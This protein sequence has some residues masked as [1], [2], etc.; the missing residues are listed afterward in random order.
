MN[1]MRGMRKEESPVPP[2]QLGGFPI[3][4]ARGRST[5]YFILGSKRHKKRGEADYSNSHNA[6]I[7]AAMDRLCGV[8]AF[9]PDQTGAFWGVGVNA[10][11]L[12]G[13]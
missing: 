7:L 4:T 10:F 12:R 11:V 8:F 5:P 1:L 3:K 9:I 2:A 13:R 6:S